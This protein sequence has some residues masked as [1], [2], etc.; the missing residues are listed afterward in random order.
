MKK[1]IFYYSRIGAHFNKFGESELDKGETK[2]IAEFLSEKLSLP[3]FEIKRDPE[4]QTSLDY[5]LEAKADKKADGVTLKPH[6]NIADYDFIYLIYNQDELLYQVIKQALRESDISKVTIMPI[7]TYYNGSANPNLVNDSLSSDF[8][9]GNFLSSYVVEN[10]KDFIN[11]YSSFCDIEELREKSPKTKSGLIFC[12]RVLIMDKDENDKRF[13]FDKHYP[14]T[15]ITDL[16]NGIGKD[17]LENHFTYF[18]PRKTLFFINQIGNDTDFSVLHDLIPSL[19]VCNNFDMLLLKY[20]EDGFERALNDLLTAKKGNLT[21]SVGIK[22]IPLEKLKT[23]DLKDIDFVACDLN[24]K[25]L[26]REYVNYLKDNNI[27]CLGYWDFDDYAENKPLN[28]IA[29]THGISL[30]TLLNL[31]SISIGVIPVNRDYRGGKLDFYKYE[32]T[33]F[34]ISQIE[35]AA[36]EE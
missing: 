5:I 32:L 30:Y 15:F 25:N 27:L 23:I 4:Y 13:F 16:E 19:S 35:N 11:H 2:I 12:P 22:D 24:L 7:A 14:A 21:R 33:Q 26:N 31:Y 8:P 1:A 34:D 20:R 36:K 28:K 3:V 18:I 9:N 10:S 29:Q 6:E 17:T